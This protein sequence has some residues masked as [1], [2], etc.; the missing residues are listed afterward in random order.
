MKVWVTS[1]F[2]YSCKSNIQQSSENVENSPRLWSAVREVVPHKKSSSTTGGKERK[3]L[4]FSFLLM[5]L[6]LPLTT[7]YWF[8]EA[9]FL[10]TW[11]RP[12]GVLR[13]L[14]FVLFVFNFSLLLTVNGALK[15]AGLISISC[16]I[17]AK[18]WFCVCSTQTHEITHPC[19]HPLIK[20]CKALCS[21]DM[22]WITAVITVPVCPSLLFLIRSSQDLL[23][24]WR[25]LVL[26]IGHF[27]TVQKSLLGDMFG[28]A[29]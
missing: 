29:S 19:V 26:Q 23:D 8:M 17:N 24:A 27:L 5:L 15:S 18:L 21:I 14:V 1:R 2:I 3:S 12:D 4:F 28:Y 10:P 7:L 20:H 9:E 6:L 25:L 16:K 13:F 11:L 22:V